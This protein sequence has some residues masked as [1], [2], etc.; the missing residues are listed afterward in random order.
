MSPL[1]DRLR[2]AREVKLSLDAL[3][4]ESKVRP[5]PKLEP[6]GDGLPAVIGL[7]KGSDPEKAQELDDFVRR[8]IPEIKRTLVKPA[9]GEGLQALWIE[10]TDGQQFPAQEVADGVLFAIGLTAHAIATGEGALLLIEEPEQM[11][12]PRRLSLVVDLFR[13]LAS[14]RACQLIF[15]THS[16]V[17]LD[18]FRDEP[19]SILLFRR[20]PAGAEVHKL[21][22]Q[23]KLMAELESL[24]PG[25]LLAQGFFNEAA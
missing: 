12:H 24:Q 25:E 7:W 5:D 20:G 15:A 1:F 6:N 21:S 9:P 23:P 8:A 22:E 4:R 13:R 17:M 11:I 18:E 3:R 10:Q 19:E 16:P 2:K 14:E